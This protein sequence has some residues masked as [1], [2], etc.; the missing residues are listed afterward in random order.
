[1]R[2]GQIRVI[3]TL[4]ESSHKLLG[5]SSQ[6]PPR[7][8]AYVEWFTRFPVRPEPHLNMYKVS[9]SFVQ[10][11]DRLVSIVPVSLIQRSIHLLPKWGRDR[12]SYLSWSR[13]DVL[14]KCNVFFVNSFKDRHTYYNVY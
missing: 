13:E 1:M 12:D 10:G 14:E 2:V 8:L 6:P 3:F 4:P 5:F 11:S 9:R 7:H